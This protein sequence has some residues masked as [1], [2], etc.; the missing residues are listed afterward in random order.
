[1]TTNADLPMTADADQS[2]TLE[3]FFDRVAH[4]NPFLANRV[5]EPSAAGADAG[6]VHHAAFARLLELARSAH[7]QQVG[8]GVM[9][10]G[11]AG[12][13]KSHLLARLWRWAEGNRAP[14]VYLQNLQAAPERL[15][16]Y[17]L[18]I[19][20]SVL[21]RRPGGSWQR[22][23]LFRLVNRAVKRRLA[24][25]GVSGPARWRQIEA[26]L[27]S[28]LDA[29]AAPVAPAIQEA[30]YRFYRA[31]QPYNKDRDPG[32]AAL[33]VQWLS[34]D[35]LDAAE[36]RRLGA[37]TAFGPSPTPAD[38]QHAK[39]V[40]IALAR[41]TAA[42]GQPLLLCFDQVDNL[43]EP[44]AA[45]LMRFLQALLDGAPNLLVVNAGVQATLV[46]WHHDRVITDSSWD[47]VAQF[48]IVLHR[49]SADEGRQIIQARLE[50]FIEPFYEIDQV[51]ARVHKDGLFPLG[52]R[53]F[54]RN[55]QDQVEVRPRDVI[56]RAREGW[57]AEQEALNETGGP[58]WLERWG[59]REGPEL[60]LTPMS[61]GQIH[62]RID[63]AVDNKIAELKAQRELHP[64]TLPPSADNLLGL[65]GNLLQHCVGPGGPYRLADLRRRPAGGA[66]ASPFDLELFRE[67]AGG[68]KVRTS[69][70]FIPTSNPTATFHFLRRILDDARRP[71]RRIIVADR[72]LPLNV[73]PKGQDVLRQL[74]DDDRSRFYAF[75][76]D[77]SRYGELDA[78]QGVIGMAAS[79]DLEIGLTAGAARRVT[80]EEVLA[81]HHRTRRFLT[82]P[83]LGLL[84]DPA[85]DPVRPGGAQAGAAPGPPPAPVAAAR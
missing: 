43:S 73:G 51:R 39:E 66:W 36:A 9:L 5:V 26:A 29:G 74:R 70:L 7:E 40:L 83:L 53:W 37:E 27:T 33:A 65:V 55:L 41:A 69:A 10:W 30:L 48:E 60:G 77:F 63:R 24:D 61:E 17:V 3:Q 64:E 72:R 49:V 76:L 6:N 67:E 32:A 85:A 20:L 68:D 34:G 42:S 79:G 8:V 13:G 58:V 45:A 31:L 59:Q 71:D 44:Q 35:S 18:K 11:P 1:M 80:A 52:R 4:R 2:P 82:H 21:T 50:Q 22:T 62:Q 75:E 54:A 56:S 46:R 38:D 81:S 19:V 23:R 12:V 14:F 16:G 57:R 78:L 15:A 28:V 84:L 25:A 47:R